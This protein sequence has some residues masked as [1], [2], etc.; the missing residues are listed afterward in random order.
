MYDQL[1]QSDKNPRNEANF[2]A[3][4]WYWKAAHQDHPGAQLNLGQMFQSGRGVSQDA[5]Q[6]LNWI[7]KAADQNHAPAQ[8]IL[9]AMHAKGRGVPQDDAEAV[10]WYRLAAEQGHAEAQY[11]LGYIYD[12]IGQQRT[13]A[14]REYN[15]EAAEWY[16]RAADQGHAAAQYYLGLMCMNGRGMPQD[17]VNAY[18]WFTLSVSNGRQDAAGARDFVAQKMNREQRAEVEGLTGDRLAMAVQPAER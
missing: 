13:D 11:N 5:A 4:E 2:E 10:T 16:R 6:A 9:G 18:L 17:L 1:G 14:P 3:V 12:Q 15:V 8:A 7:R